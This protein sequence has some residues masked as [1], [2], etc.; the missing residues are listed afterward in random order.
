MSWL[1]KRYKGTLPFLVFCA[2]ALLLYISLGKDP[3]YIPSPLIGKPAPDFTLPDLENRASLSK[4]DMLG[5]VWMLNVWASWCAACLEEHPLLNELSTSNMIRIVGLNYK[6]SQNDALS[7]LDKHGNPYAF[8]AVDKEGE[9]GIDYGVYGVPE[10]F[11]IDKDGL[12]QYKH[13]GPLT[14]KFLQDKIIPLIHALKGQ[15]S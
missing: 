13:T 1:I 9:V 8:I 6:D 14:R 15:Q 5:R 2:L 4:Q 7:W 11:L 12:I 3:E 10:T